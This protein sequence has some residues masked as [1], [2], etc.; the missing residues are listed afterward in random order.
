MYRWNLEGRTDMSYKLGFANPDYE[1]YTGLESY[2]EIA[3]AI[4]EEVEK[5]V[6]DG[7][8]DMYEPIWADGT[9]EIPSGAWEGRS[10]EEYQQ[11][12]SE[13]EDRGINEAVYRWT[14]AAKYA[15][16]DSSFEHSPTQFRFPDGTT[17]VLSYEKD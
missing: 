6:A 9:P 3:E 13:A 5:I 16:W 4:R 12:C 14:E 11:M 15:L 8:S 10:E 1:P 17:L 7:G 2:E